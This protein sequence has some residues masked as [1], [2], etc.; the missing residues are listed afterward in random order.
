MHTLKQKVTTEG[1]ALCQG[2][3]PGFTH[4]VGLWQST[5]GNDG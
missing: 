5:G 4:K 3:E 2:E 1:I